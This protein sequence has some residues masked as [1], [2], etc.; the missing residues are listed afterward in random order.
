MTVSAAPTPTHTAYAVPIGMCLVAQPRP[1][2]L[3]ASATK[4]TTDGPRTDN[5]SDVPSAVAQTASKTAL[6]SRMIH[7]TVSSP[8]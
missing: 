3:S 5:P 2:M 8:P 6:T 4:K 7:G 1:S